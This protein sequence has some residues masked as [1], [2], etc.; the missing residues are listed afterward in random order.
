MIDKRAH[1]VMTTVKA[2]QPRLLAAC[3]NAL[4]GPVYDFVPEYVAAGR[5]HRRTNNARPASRRSPPRRESTFRTPHRCSASAA[6]PPGLDGQRT[7]KEIAYRITS[8]T[9][10]RADPPRLAALLRGHWHI[11]NRLY[12]V[13]DVT[14]DEDRSQIRTGTG[15]RVIASLRNL[16]I[17]ALRIAG[18]TNIAAALRW[19]ARDHTRPLA[20]LELTRLCRGPARSTTG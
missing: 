19:A 18:H 9:A 12:W 15:P 7:G 10:D 8:Q 13:R 5:G 17:S 6:T 4:A 14:Y 2:N 20:I 3:R 1:Y 16:A 11:E